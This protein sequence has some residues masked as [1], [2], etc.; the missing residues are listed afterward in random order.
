M[1]HHI[2]ADWV[3]DQDDRHSTSGNVFILGGGAICWSSKKQAVVSL[4]IVEAEYI[5]LSAAAQEAAW[6]QK[7]FLD[8]P[9]KGNLVL[10]LPHN[11]YV[12][13][14]DCIFPACM[15]IWH[16]QILIG[17]GIILINRCNF[18]TVEFPNCW[19]DIVSHA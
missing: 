2:D 19:K 13:N 5:A 4:A 6:L 14:N 9:I 10:S 18:Q 7:L 1:T 15:H 16:Q 11:N 3:R 17:V 12:H 8:I